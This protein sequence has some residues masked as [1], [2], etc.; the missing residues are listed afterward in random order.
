[1]EKND[2]VPIDMVL[3][4]KQYLGQ[5][6]LIKDMGIMTCYVMNS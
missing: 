3:E 4:L 5:V 2:R 1:M 6:I